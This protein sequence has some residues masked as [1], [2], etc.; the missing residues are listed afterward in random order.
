M[1]LVQGIL[2]SQQASANT[3]ALAL[4]VP[5]VMQPSLLLHGAPSGAQANRQIPAPH[6]ATLH[7][8]GRD[9]QSDAVTHSGGGP[10]P[11]RRLLRQ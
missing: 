9:L 2:S 7:E 3:Q 6:V 10:Q 11:R 5:M 1:S 4:Q 8:A